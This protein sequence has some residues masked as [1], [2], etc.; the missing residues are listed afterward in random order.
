MNRIFFHF[1]CFGFLGMPGVCSGN[2]GMLGPSIPKG[3]LHGSIG[4]NMCQFT[5]PYKGLIGTC[6]EMFGVVFLR[7]W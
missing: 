7:F 4:V 2:R 3:A 1:G 5:I 6:W